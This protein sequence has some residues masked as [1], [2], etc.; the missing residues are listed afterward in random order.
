MSRFH[1]ASLIHP[2]NHPQEL[3]DFLELDAQ[4]RCVIDYIVYTTTD[5]AAHALNLEPTEKMRSGL[6][7]LSDKMHNKHCDFK[8]FVSNV[9][10]RSRTHIPTVL[11]ALLY[12]K[13]ARLHLD[14]PP[15]GWILHRLFLGALI[16]ATK[17]TL[18]SPHHNSDWADITGT[19]GRRDIGKMEFQMFEVLDMRLSFT[20]DELR[21]LRLD[22]LA[23]YTTELAYLA[24]QK[25]HPTPVKS[26][27]PRSRSPDTTDLHKRKKAKFI[28]EEDD[29]SDRES[30]SD[31]PY[32][33]SELE[34]SYVF[35]SPPQLSSS[36]SS[37]SSTA[38]VVTPP[39]EC[40]VKLVRSRATVDLCAGFNSRSPSHSLQTS[41]SPTIEVP[42]VDPHTTMENFTKSSATGWQLL[43]WFK[44]SP[45]TAAKR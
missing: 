17:Y 44:S 42:M 10:R 25:P 30:E 20:Q 16:L 43:Q 26:K 9:I 32:Y 8:Q 40:S 15:L 35:P 36:A 14:V 29:E 4:D 41:F 5:V 19:F 45:W 1:P 18:D 21:Q 22:I 38:S 12:L 24:N 13:R 31:E 27:T 23:A 37:T 11:V 6:L 33:K 34:G 2:D 28:I 39:E 7:A 3:L